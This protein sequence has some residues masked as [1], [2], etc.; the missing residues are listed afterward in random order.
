[1]HYLAGERHLSRENAAGIRLRDEERLV[2]R[3]AE[4]QIGH[5]LSDAGFDEMR[6]LPATVK[7]PNADAK[8]TNQKAVFLIQRQAVRPRHPARELEVQADLRDRS[9][10]H[11]GN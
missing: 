5:V 4:G 1:M 2:L 11:Q 9:V 7:S 10:G 6:R 8:V 3:T